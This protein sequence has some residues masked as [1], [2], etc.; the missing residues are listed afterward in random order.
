MITYFTLY[1]TVPRFCLFTPRPVSP[2]VIPY[3]PPRRQ[4]QQQLLLS[5]PLLLVP[6]H[7]DHH[8]Q[9]TQEE[10]EQT[11]SPD[12]RGGKDKKTKTNLRKNTIIIGHQAGCMFYVSLINVKKYFTNVYILSYCYCY[13]GCVRHQ[14]TEKFGFSSPKKKKIPAGDVRALSPLQKTHESTTCACA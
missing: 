3:P 11:S 1:C 6:F 2:P 14:H 9:G 8:H 4:S 10:E 13:L 7:R 12:A 5:P